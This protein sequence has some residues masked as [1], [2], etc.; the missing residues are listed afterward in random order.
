MIVREG[1]GE[2][3]GTYNV[4]LR[5]VFEGFGNVLLVYER[6]SELVESRECLV[7]T[8]SGYDGSAGF[9]FCGTSLSF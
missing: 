9:G 1:E 6:L 3:E 5:D 4:I 2:R 8:W 7:H